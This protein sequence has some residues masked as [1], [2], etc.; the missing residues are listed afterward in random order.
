MTRIK[1]LTAVLAGVAVLATSAIAQE[2]AVMVEEETAPVSLSVGVDLASAYV[3]RG[4]TFNDGIVAQPW[5][6]ATTSFGLNFGVWANFDIDDYDGTLEKNQFS[7]I[8]IYIGWG[9]TLADMVDVG[10]GYCEYTYPMYGGEAD[11]EIALS[12]GMPLGPIGLGVA[13]YFGVD[14]GIEKTIY[15]EATAEYGVDITEELSAAIYGS[16]GY[17]IDDNDGGENGFQDYTAGASLSYGIFGA[18]VTYI[19]QGDDKVLPEEQYGYDV[20][21]VGM[22]SVG[23]DF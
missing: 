8:D 9:T 7:E 17:L 20:E 10:I 22:L 13:A 2:A 11:R 19:G 16:A 14:G 15:L 5:M 21:V 6:D 1:T 3:F 4:V 12:A 23:Y 18:S